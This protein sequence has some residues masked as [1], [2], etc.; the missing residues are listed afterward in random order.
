[1][2]KY[3]SKTKEP[4][5]V[6]RQRRRVEDG[7]GTGHLDEYQPFI[8]IERGGFQSRGRSHLIFDE[9]VGRHYH[10]LSDLELL[11][12]M[13]AW[14]CDPFD[15]REQYA[16]HLY[17]F[18]PEFAPQQTSRPRG[19]LAIAAKLG[20]KHPGIT[21]LEPRMMTTDFLVTFQGK[22]KLAIYAKY[23]NDLENASVRTR[24]LKSIEE[25]YWRERRVRFMVMNE[26][27]FTWLIADQLMWAIDGMKW[28]RDLDLLEHLLEC[29]DGTSSYLPMSMRLDI[30]ARSFGLDFST[31]VRAFKYAVLTRRWLIKHPQQELDLSCAWAGHRPRSHAPVTAVSFRNPGK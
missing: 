22:T 10:L 7:R 3:C 9:R 4:R 12:F 13:W 11:I 30:C 16:L 20:V 23:R 8:Q 24:E 17:E 18:D 1:M 28:E 2:E 6:R 29:L 25:R 31:A 15:I 14:S 21:R 19:T 27:P 5:E 26:E